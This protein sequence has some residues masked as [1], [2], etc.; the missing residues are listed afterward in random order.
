MKKCLLCGAALLAAAGAGAQ[1]YISPAPEAGFDIKGGKDYVVLYAPESVIDKMGD[2]LV[3]DNNLDPAEVKNS[4]VYWVTDWD[5][6]LLTIYNVPPQ[7]G[8]VNSFGDSEFINATPLFEWG[9]G[10]FTPKK[11]Y[12]YD[13]SK[14]TADHHLHIGLRDFG[15]SPSKYKFAVGSQST[16]KTN[17]F[18][19]VA[20]LGV[21]VP[22]GEYAGI[23]E[24]PNG[25]DGKWYYIDV[26]VA[27]L[28]DENGEFGFTYDFSKPITDAGFIFSFLDPVCSE[29]TTSGPEPGE[30]IYTHTVTKLG[31]ALSLDHIFFY[32]P[33]T[34]GVDGIADKAEESVIAIYDLAGRR[35]ENP[36]QG[37]Y[38]VKTNLGSRKMVV[39]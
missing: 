34:A 25:N 18:Q 24:M 31:S 10:A 1:S 23:G 36:S 17:G 22:S 33:D 4:I 16:I 9:T 28:I 14:V 20:G 15:A 37:I 11:D 35:V 32:V 6:K 26:P 30:S 29:Y 38:I 27:D 12:S 8:E 3:G 21:G 5:S 19:I 39:R 13:L 7:E 2:K